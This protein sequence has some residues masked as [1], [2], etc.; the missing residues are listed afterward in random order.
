M[1]LHQ[2]AGANNLFCNPQTV[3][4]QASAGRWAISSGVL[5]LYGSHTIA[6]LRLVGL[7]QILSLRIPCLSL[8]ST[9]VKLL[10]KGVAWFTGF[11]TPTCNLLAISFLK[12]SF[13]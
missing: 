7:R 1:K 6:L 9:S 3:I 12:A 8:P 11:K 2:A 10:I 4:T 5:K 13:K